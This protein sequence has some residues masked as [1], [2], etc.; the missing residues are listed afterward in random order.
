MSTIL[1]AL[2][3]ESIS[4]PGKTAWTFLNDKG[5]PVDCYTYQVHSDLSSYLPGNNKLNICFT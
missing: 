3:K 5:D 1:E 2:A 4:Q